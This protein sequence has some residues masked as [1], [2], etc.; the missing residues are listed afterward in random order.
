MCEKTMKQTNF[1]KHDKVCFIKREFNMSKK[2]I[3]EAIGGKPVAQSNQDLENM[4]IKL[5]SE[6]EKYIDL[7]KKFTQEANQVLI[8]HSVDFDP[9]S[10][11]GEMSLNEETTKEYKSE[12]KIFSAWAFKNHLNP[13]LPTS[14]NSY[15]SSLKH[16]V[17]T[18]KTKRNRI[19]S[20]M[21]H[22]TGQNIMLSRIRRRV[23]IIPKY[24]MSPKEIEKYLE[25]QKTINH[26][27]FLIQLL[28][29][30]HGCRV[31]SVSGIQLKHLDFLEEG[32]KMYLPDTKTGTRE[33]EVGKQLRQL[34]GNLVNEKKLTNIDSFVFEAGPSFNLRRR[35]NILCTRIN[36][37]INES[38]VLR[39]SNNFKFSSHMFRHSKAFT[40]FR[41][42][43]EKGKEA[44]RSAIGHQPGTSSIN[45]YLI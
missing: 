17:S 15:I 14:A 29:A 41:E 45:Y 34:L 44:A 31:H 42:Y 22:L 18:I 6:N 16:Q 13:I 3:L 33:L 40:I 11:I 36:R 2:Q 35:A 1:S 10:K 37:R 19:Q 28:M 25:E 12:W 23:K 8:S 5:T 26:E 30:M 9:L 7:I 20:I 4:N 24:K 32:N 38:H 43:L 21:R 27:D 39:K